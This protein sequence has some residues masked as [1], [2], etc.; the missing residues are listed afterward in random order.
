I[1][2]G[3]FTKSNNGGSNFN[4][5][6]NLP[7]SGS[8]NWVTPFLVSQHNGNV[9]YAG[10]TRVW[11]STNAGMSFAATTSS[12]LLGTDNIDVLAESPSNP[13]VLYVGINQYLFRSMDGGATFTQHSGGA[14]SHVITGIAVDPL[15]P[16]HIVVSRSGY[17][18]GQKVFESYNGGVSYSNISGSLPNIPANAVAFEPGSSN[19]RYVGTDLGVFVR[20][21]VLGDWVPFNAGLPNVIVND[22]EI[23]TQPRIVR[24]GTYGRGVWQSPFASDLLV[25]PTARISAAPASVCGTGD[26]VQLADASLGLVTSWNWSVVPAGATLLGAS[27]A[28]PKLVASQSGTYSI[29]LVASNAYGSDTAM[30]VQAVAVG[31]FPIPAGDGFA[32]GLDGRW[33]IENPHRDATWEAFATAG[34]DG[35]GSSMRMPHFSLGA[36]AAGRG[37][38][39]VSPVYNVTSGASLTFDAAYRTT[40]T[41]G[42]SDTLYV[43]VQ[44]CGSPTWTLLATRVESGSQ[45]WATGQAQA[46]AF[47]PASAADWRRDSLFLGTLAGA[48]RFKFEARHGGGNHLYLDRFRVIPAAAPAP[49]ADFIST[50]SACVTKPVQFYAAGLPAPG[51]FS[52]PGALGATYTWSFPGG[53][54]ASS[55]A[56]NPT[57]SYATPGL[58]T[59]TLTVTTAAGTSS[60]S[61]TV[62]IAAAVVP[63]VSI[64]NQTGSV[65]ANSPATFVATA[66]NGGATPRYQ[67]TVNG[68][69]RG[70]NSSTFT[71]SSLQNGDVVRC[72]LYSAEECPSVAKVTSAGITVTVLPL[73]ATTAGSYAAECVGSAPI[74]LV[75]TPAGGVWSGT[76]VV[77]SNFDPTGLGPGTYEVTYAFT[78]SAGCTGTSTASIQLAPA[79][80]V[81]LNFSTDVLCVSDPAVNPG[82]GYPSGGTYLLGGSSTTSINPANLGVGSYGLTYRYS[83]GLCLVE[84]VD[85]F[86]VV[87]APP[88][89]TIHD[90][91]GDSLYCPQTALNPRWTVQWLDANQNPIPGATG[92]SF[93]APTTGTYYVRLRAGNSC[94]ATSGP[95]IV[96]STSEF[97]LR[98]IQVQ[99]NPSAGRFEVTWTSAGG[100]PWTAEL[101]SLDGSLLGTYEGTDPSLAL[102][103]SHLPQG[104]YALRVEQNGRT[105]SQQLVRL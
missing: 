8:G 48:A 24:I 59:A 80:N 2:Y 88:A 101:R 91:N 35:D 27:T 102:D 19:L 81:F 65:C 32:Q 4:A 18:A 90:W 85:S 99:P 87:A 13:D 11:K 79:P 39:L 29:Q 55:T 31:G 60:L 64:A 72:E 100:T 92:S 28:N 52:G 44:Q 30:F 51:S 49:V 67:W 62:A 105:A 69:P 53:A 41:T 15:D 9:L 36:T 7:P 43:Y 63:S 45:N 40:S 78:N 71:V 89:P 56:A 37:D 17:V 23:L 10:F 83:N 104:V 57:V 68:V 86:H 46:S 22:I 82:G 98:G 1:Y 12:N 50:D 47:T 16:L 21:N 38:A 103:L 96:M 6:F 75:G 97:R 25:R 5:P 93:I 58:K 54:P 66:V 33:S 61:K 84:R 95:S 94:T 26:T 70:F 77:G 3:D 34:S 20:D 74:A 76:G 42:P 14:G 73:P